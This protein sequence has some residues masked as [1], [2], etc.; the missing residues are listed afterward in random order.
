MVFSIFYDLGPKTGLRAEI[1]AKS[2][3]KNEFSL[4]IYKK[5]YEFFSKKYMVF[6]QFFFDSA[7]CK[8]EGL[9]VLKPPT[10]TQRLAA[11]RLY[12]APHRKVSAGSGPVKQ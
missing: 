7:G 12:V 1:P 3:K 5:F 11:V 6:F 9:P 8:T 4:E 2:E 10:P